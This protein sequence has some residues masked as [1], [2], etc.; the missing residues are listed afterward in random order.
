M[1]LQS[2]SQFFR[3]PL[4]ITKSLVKSAS[5]VLLI[6]SIIA[7]ADF[8]NDEPKS[9]QVASIDQHRE[10]AH[11]L[12]PSFDFANSVE[13]FVQLDNAKTRELNDL[14]DLS[15]KISQNSVRHETQFVIFRKLAS[16][17]PILALR[18]LNEIPEN[19]REVS[20]KG[21][22]RE[23]SLSDLDAALDSA[24]S[25]SVPL[26]LAA[27]QAILKYRDDLPRD[28]RLK[29]SSE[30]G[31]KQFALIQFSSEEAISNLNEPDKAWDILLTDNVA[32]VLQLQLL[33]RIGLEWA[34]VEGFDA[35][36]HINASTNMGNR[37]LMAKVVSAIADSDPKGAFAHVAELSAQSPYPFLL[38]AIVLHWAHSDPVAALNA[39]STLNI[40]H[41][42]LK[43]LELAV[44]N[45]WSASQPGA[46]LDE[47]ARF[48]PSAQVEIV[49]DALEELARTNP[50]DAIERMRS[51]KELIGNSTGIEKKLVGIWSQ[52]QPLAALEWVLGEAQPQSA[53]RLE[54]IESVL[55]SLSRSHPERAMEVALQEPEINNQ[56]GLEHLVI[57]EISDFDIELA[58]KMLPQVR[59][60]ARGLSFAWIGGAIMRTGDHS[61]ALKLGEELSG[62]HRVLFYE[63]VGDA[64]AFT[65]PQKMLNALKDIQSKEIQSVMAQRLL[66]VND[67]S[68]VIA[69]EE[70][71]Q[72]E[73][74]VEPQDQYQKNEVQ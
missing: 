16:I 66:Q 40:D 74:L 49:E 19:E 15:K 38:Q 21:I 26:R 27:L 44:A 11:I 9:D 36:F 12:P 68:H 43:T 62:Y 47:L 67:F 22:F 2:K 70:I 65:H 56:L 64:W 35:L 39:L 10:E 48:S 4:G 54:L 58:L 55:P 50:R 37:S 24:K 59:D 5:I 1:F 13:F 7:N 42:G 25:L 33:I 73:S 18:Q 60:S 69:P 28:V 6:L 17:D 32:D 31:G 71:E 30:L 72:V 46:L 29:I 3:F 45:S 61:R 14:L 20:I 53:R 57:N 52:D 23:W 41:R 34:E 51:L 63:N 8:S